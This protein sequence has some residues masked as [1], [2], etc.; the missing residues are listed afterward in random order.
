MKAVPRVMRQTERGKSSV[1]FE[2]LPEELAAHAGHVGGLSD[3]LNTALDAANAVSMGDGAYGV[4]CSFL[5]PIINP[6]TTSGTDA[7]GA[8]VEGMG[9]TS[10]EIR[11]AVSSYEA[12]DEA[13][14]RPFTGSV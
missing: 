9:V 5:P 14:A 12:S 1:S 4:L 7:I 3:R 6:V 10:D 13:N 2:V 11:G 8:A